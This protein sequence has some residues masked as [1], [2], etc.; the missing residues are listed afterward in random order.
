MLL[1]FGPRNEPTLAGQSHVQV[2]PGRQGMAS[3]T[4]FLRSGAPILYAR[5]MRCTAPGLVT[6]L[7]LIAVLAGPAQ[8]QDGAGSAGGAD[9][10]ILGQILGLQQAIERLASA[11]RGEVEAS[12]RPANEEELAEHLLAL[13][14]E[15]DELL[16]VLASRRAEPEVDSPLPAEGEAV[17]VAPPPA[18]A[19]EG[20]EKFAPVEVV[21]AA[22][23][24]VSS[25]P[26][27]DAQCAEFEMFDTNEDGVVSALDRYWRYFRLWRDDGDGVVEDSEVSRLYDAG[28]RE[29]TTAL[30]TYRT[31]DGVAGDVLEGARIRLDLMGKNGGMATLAIDADRL[32]HGGEFELRDGAGAAV[33]GL[34][35]LSSS[36]STVA[37]DGAERPL[38]CA[39]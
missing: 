33:S 5:G 19:E 11:D 39:D 27:A 3:A 9:E 26:E 30:G 28:V 10:E 6:G 15:I 8:S 12:E 21:E 16:T 37:A 35:A 1:R 29:L 24:R 38:S 25:R 32:A 31:A 20:S 14:R 17:K 4:S 2:S 23:A 34:Q 22:E 36:M 13:R 18:V 7:F